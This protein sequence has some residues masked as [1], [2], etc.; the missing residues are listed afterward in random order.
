[1][2]ADSHKLAE[3]ER[4][5][6]D[7]RE[8]VQARYPHGKTAFEVQL[9]DLMPIVRARDAAE[10]KVASI[11]TVNPRPGG[12]ANNLV[13]RW[14]RFVSRV[15]DW[16]VREQV[17]FNRGAINC[18]NATMEA[19]NELNRAVKELAERSEAQQADLRSE[20]AQVELLRV[21][22]RELSDVR[23]HWQEWRKEWERKLSINE[24]Q[25][26]RSAA[27]LQAAFNHRA[28]LM[29]GTFRDIAKSQ[30]TDF[31]GALNRSAIDVQQR[32]WAD[33]DRIRTEYE[34]LIHHELRKVRQR[35]FLT[36]PTVASSNVA[37]SAANDDDYDV[38]H[39]AEKFRGHP[40]RIR[41]GLD[42]YVPYFKSAKNVLD[43]G[44]GR[45]E[46]LEK[47]RDAGVS[48]RGIDLHDES[49]ALCLSR[50]LTAEKADMYSFLEEQPDGAFDG[51]FCAQVIEHLKPVEVPKLLKLLSQKTRKGG[52]VAF[53][54]PNPECLAIFAT[55]FYLDPTH[56]RPV[57]S[58]LLAFYLE[59][60]GFGRIEILPISPAVETMPSLAS[61]PPDFREVF[62][63][64]LDYAAIARKL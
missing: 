55:H 28:T 18:I 63:G 62:F 50:N 5:I 23:L 64:G 11:G 47:M 12:F 13:Q 59:E 60:A 7:I 39:F 46:F 57:P 40:A 10:S 33:L 24:V 49:I 21:E 15:L 48:A 27:D 19:L 32:L 17:E 42:R 43:I 30:H 20:L 58:A 37:A 31:E 14:K 34:E 4:A 22:A 51:V 61:L 9:A 16:H 26:L 8:R 41:E 36:A 54:T 44:C 2:A 1:M 6:A 53:E 35:A 38:L 52:V 3:L 25:F 45:G 56:V 29:E